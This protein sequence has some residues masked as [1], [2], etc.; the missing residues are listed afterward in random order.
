MITILGARGFIGS[1]LVKSL[2]SKHIDYY[3]PRRDEDIA[4]KYLGHVIY[5]IG[6]TADFRHRPFDTVEA[7]V[8]KLL[9]V[10]RNCKYDSLLYLSSTRL[11]KLSASLA[12]EEDSLQV[13]PLNSSDLFNISKIMGESLLHACGREAVIARISNVYGNDFTSENF[14]ASILREAVSTG[15]VVLRTSLDS[16]KDYVSIDDLTD[17]LL[18]IAHSGKQLIYNV[19]RGTNVSNHELMAKL[20]SLTGC[21][22]EVAPDAET[23]K[24]PRI[25]IERIASEFHYKPSNVLNDLDDLIRQYRRYQAMNK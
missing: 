9:E 13:S 20:R 12:C 22:V 4:E 3:A 1:H 23:I 21:Q 19:A 8:C 16:E 18:E 17:I 24:F 14:L 2:L 5:C 11:Y 6:L 25:S 15:R 7:H 10:V